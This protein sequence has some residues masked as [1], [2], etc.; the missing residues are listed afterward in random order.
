M[1]LAELVEGYLHLLEELCLAGRGGGR[2]LGPLLEEVDVRRSQVAPSHSELH[3][4]DQLAVHARHELLLLL[5][6]SRRLLLLLRLVGKE[7]CHVAVAQLQLAEILLL[8]AHCGQLHAREQLQLVLLLALRCL[9]LVD[10]LRLR[11]FTGSARVRVKVVVPLQLDAHPRKVLRL[12]QLPVERLLALCLSPRRTLVREAPEDPPPLPLHRKALH[13]RLEG[14]LPLPLDLWLEELLVDLLEAGHHLGLVARRL[15]L[16]ARQRLER[17]LRLLGARLVDGRNASADVV[18]EGRRL[19]LRPGHDGSP[20]GSVEALRELADGAALAEVVE[21]LVVRAVRQDREARAEQVLHQRHDRLGLGAAC[22]AR[23]AAWPAE[24]VLQRNEEG[25]EHELDAPAHL[26]LHCLEVPAQDGADPRH[27]LHAG[28]DV[29]FADD[30]RRH[31]EG[32]AR[33]AARPQHHALAR[34]LD[35]L[36]HLRSVLAVEEV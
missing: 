25:G 17:G 9:C 2:V 34:L 36:V 5:A 10:A 20:A 3:G 11:L 8:L 13:I 22:R 26:R 28:S 14:Y 27:R 18:R 29:A 21:L 31:A 24:R 16:L 19:L 12:V 15:L 6:G 1:H 33:D 32:N 35:D 4:G 7:G 23:A 30:G